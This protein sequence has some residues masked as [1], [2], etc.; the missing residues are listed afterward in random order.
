MRSAS[1][2]R[3]VFL[4]LLAALAALAWAALWG[5]SLSP[6]ARWLEHGDFAAD[7]PI[8]ALCRALP[9]GG[10]LVP[11]AFSGIV[12]VLM[13]AAMMLPSA[14]PLFGAFD[15]LAAGR[16]DR[17]SLLG[18]LVLGYVAVWALFGIVA[19]GLHAALLAA[20]QASS[21]LAAKAWM[22]GVAT[23]AIAGAF[24][25]SRLKHRC[26]DQ[27][28]TPLGFVLQHWRGQAQ[29]WHAFVLGAHHGLFCVGCCW[30]LMLLMFVVGAGNLGWMLLL[31]ALMAMEKNLSGGRRLSAPLGIVLLAWA[32]A[33]WL[34]RSGV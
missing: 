16:A 33:L 11:A 22:L 17:T 4:P 28:R 18:L 3:R 27:C 6:Y 10:W 8:A 29:A 13:I 9:A 20:V 25:F 2:H 1:R 7:G 24:Q 12:W 31:A 15:R 5:L 23:I 19:H 21:L 14:L 30:A 32:A 26:L 34:L